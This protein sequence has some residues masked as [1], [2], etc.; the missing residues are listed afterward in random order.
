MFRDTAL[1]LFSQ[2]HGLMKMLLNFYVLLLKFL[3]K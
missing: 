2:E 3:D 1:V